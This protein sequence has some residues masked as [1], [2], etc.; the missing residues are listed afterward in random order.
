[1]QPNNPLVLADLSWPELEQVKRSVGLVLIPVGSS[2]QHGPNLAFQTDTLLATAV[3]MELG[4]RLGPQ[5][6]I[7]PA[8]PWGISPHHM[9][10]PGTITLEIPTFT[11]VLRDVV[12]SLAHHGFR[13]VLFVN[14]HGG[15]EAAL[16]VAVQQIGDQLDLDFVGTCNYFRLV[17]KAQY[18]DRI[19][20]TY[21]GHACEM[22][23]SWALALQP[24]LVKQAQLG[25]GAM[26]LPALAFR[27]KLVDSRMVAAWRMDEMSANGAF[28][29]ATQAS[30]ELGHETLAPVFA[31]LTQTI[32]AI[33][34]YMPHRAQE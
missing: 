17:D 30:A 9:R 14:G 3:A 26:N 31:Q 25:A 20:S 12:R 19:R 18:P 28:G 24:Q 8:V 34:D 5:L 16:G 15:N 1:M 4:R 32:Q 21:T 29:D 13:K 2:E 22:E 11:A 27:Q 23:T 33:L 7:A 10:F 6:L